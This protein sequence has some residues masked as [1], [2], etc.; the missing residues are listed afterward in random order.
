M[1]ECFSDISQSLVLLCQ[2]CFSSTN[3]THVTDIQLTNKT[4]SSRIS[5]RSLKKRTLNT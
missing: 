5:I 1:N 4:N 2:K 3:K